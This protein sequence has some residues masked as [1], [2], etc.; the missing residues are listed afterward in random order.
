MDE[1][2]V[3]LFGVIGYGAVLAAL[4]SATRRWKLSSE[5][6][7]RI[8]HVFGALLAILFGA[9]LS[10]LS[11]L[12]LVA[13]F[14]AVMLYSRKHKILQHIHGV[15]RLTFGEEFF[16]LGV[17]AA[18]LIANGDTMIFIYAMLVIGIAD[19]ITGIAM[20]RYGNHAISYLVC[21]FVVGLIMLS[22]GLLW[23]Q[24]L[25]VALLVSGVE[26]ISPYGS[27]NLS[28]PASMALSMRFL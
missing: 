22:T 8:A 4:E 5:W 17:V 27:D 7:R 13:F 20:D 11:F 18:F 26:R 21:S 25:P 16:A 15:R 3:F 24:V 23:Q 28:M 1:L 9:V 2:H 6:T 14:L 19:P 12:L 10:R